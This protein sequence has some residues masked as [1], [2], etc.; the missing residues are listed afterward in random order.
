MKKMISP[1]IKEITKEPAKELTKEQIE[2]N[3]KRN[4][5]INDWTRIRA[6][7]YSI[8]HL[9]IK[10]SI[11]RGMGVF[12]KKDFNKGEIV[13]Y[14]HSMVYD[15]RE[16]YISDSTIMQ[17]AYRHWCDCSD[18]KKHGGV[19]VTPFGFGSIYNSAETQETAN[20]EFWV[21]SKHRLI[22]FEATKEI[23]KGEEILTW[24][25][26]GY[27]DTWC[28]PKVDWSKTEDGKKY[29]SSKTGNTC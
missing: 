15:W 27:Y 5:I 8:D 13:E 2:I 17:Y 19:K 21:L 6:E 25:G 23:K 24:W 22:A 20:L 4:Q 14:C 26:Q 16:K 7:G 3:A 1:N 18:C 28:K 9:E 10:S 12:A 11:I 29:I